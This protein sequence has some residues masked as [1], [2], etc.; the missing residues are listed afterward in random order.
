VWL[1]EPE[2]PL[3]AHRYP[4]ASLAAATQ[5]NDSPD[6][7]YG[8][9][10]AEPAQISGRRRL[11]DA[12][13]GSLQ[14]QASGPVRGLRQALA[15]HLLPAESEKDPPP[16]RSVRE[17][18]ALARAFERFHQLV[19]NDAA[20]LDLAVVAPPTRQIE[21]LSA[22]FE[23]VQEQAQ[24]RS[25]YGF[26]IVALAFVAAVLSIELFTKVLSD[27][28]W[29]VVAYLA[30]LA[31]ILTVVITARVRRWQGQAEDYRA[32]MEMLRVQR[33]WWSAGLAA[34][35]DRRHLQG[36]RPELARVRDAVR[37][38][39][40][41]VWLRS[42]WQSGVPPKSD[43]LDVRAGGEVARSTTDLVGA[44]QK[45]WIGEQIRYYERSR[46]AR[47]RAASWRDA[48][49]WFLFGSSVALALVLCLWLFSPVARAAFADAAEQGWA[50]PALLIVAGLLTLRLI[51]HK[52][53]GTGAWLLTAACGVAAAAALAVAIEAAGSPFAALLNRIAPPG[54]EA[55]EAARAAKYLAIL[56]TVML[57]ALAG[58]VRYLM[59]KFNLEAESREYRNVLEAFERAEAVLAQGT[60]PTN[61]LPLDAAAAA[62]LIEELGLIALRENETWLK[63]HRER[64][65]QPMV[66]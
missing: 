64:P 4:V 6:A 24:R 40:V 62:R 25:T 58:A 47:E 49:T 1:I 14:A 42:N 19:G 21:A 61:G 3:V 53:R 23:P 15:W 52:V 38:M 56:A 35:C 46:V 8:R 10:A 32:A 29:V 43:W 44:P 57:T 33:A 12:L 34:R 22:A 66:G 65:L 9:K 28:P 18:L 39:L 50:L 60:D 54:A 13:A 51:L 7:V 63:A 11:A 45:D 55:I 17:T 20:L 16:R 27:N 30:A 31:I 41:W 37:T 26:R 36:V 2:A 5:P 59:E 48:L